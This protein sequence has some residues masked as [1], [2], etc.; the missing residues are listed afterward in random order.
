MRLTPW[1]TLYNPNERVMSRGMPVIMRPDV[2]T[3]PSEIRM[4][5]PAPDPEPVADPGRR[6]RG[7]GSIEL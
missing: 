5:G 7:V 2:I 1:G 4:R 6:W 3:A